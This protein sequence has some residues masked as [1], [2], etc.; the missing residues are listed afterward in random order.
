MFNL[1]TRK[2]LLN[3]DLLSVGKSPYELA[4]LNVTLLI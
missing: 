2:H 1:L 3:H 4:K